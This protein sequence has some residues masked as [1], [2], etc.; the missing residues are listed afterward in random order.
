MTLEDLFEE[1]KY[2]LIVNENKHAVAIIIYD[3]RT[4]R[5]EDWEVI[6]IGIGSEIFDKIWEAINYLKANLKG[7]KE[8]YYYD[9][10]RDDEEIWQKLED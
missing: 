1:R 10:K 5:I 8:L 6:I 9:E 2:Q 7:Y 4:V 3:K